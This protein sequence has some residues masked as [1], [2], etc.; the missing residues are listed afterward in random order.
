MTQDFRQLGPTHITSESPDAMSGS[1]ARAATMSSAGQA[2]GNPAAK[3]V[4]AVF[5]LSALLMIAAGVWVLF[6]APDFLPAEVAPM[7]GG[8]LIFVGVVELTIV[9]FLRKLMT[10]PRLL[11]QIRKAKEEAEKARRRQSGR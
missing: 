1:A 10:N 9:R 11:E 5:T 3:T 7:I 2:A 4:G 8:G 6:D